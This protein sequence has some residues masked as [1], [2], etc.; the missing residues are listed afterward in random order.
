MPDGLYWLLLIFTSPGIIG[1]V[2]VY[3]MVALTIQVF[4]VIPFGRPLWI[5]K[6]DRLFSACTNLIPAVLVIFYYWLIKTYLT[7][8]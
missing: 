1:A 6:P 7:H 8:G 3:F 5:P 2:V 4:V